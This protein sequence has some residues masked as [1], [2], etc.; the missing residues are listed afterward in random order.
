MP[1]PAGHELAHRLRH[2]SATPSVGHRSL[3]DARLPPGVHMLRGWVPLQAC[4]QGCPGVNAVQICS[5]RSF[6]RDTPASL[7][8][9]FTGSTLGLTPTI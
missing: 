7:A 6:L 1:S 4:L 5:C 9:Y 2:A 3:R 8:S